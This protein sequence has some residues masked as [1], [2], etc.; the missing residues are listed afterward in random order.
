VFL[1]PSVPDLRETLSANLPPWGIPRCRQHPIF[2][3]GFPALPHSLSS[4]GNKSCRDAFAHLRSGDAPSSQA[5]H[6][7]PLSIYPL[8]LASSST[9]SSPASPSLPRLL[10]LQRQA[11]PLRLPRY[12][13][14]FVSGTFPY[15][16]PPLAPTMVRHGIMCSSLVF[17]NLNS[18]ANHGYSTQGILN[19]GYS[20]TSSATSTSA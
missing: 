10:H 4:C 6:R 16:P 17:G 15:A 20:P 1:A 11:G 8:R 12:I 5:T 13:T 14:V 9:T 19:H 2:R 3:S 18:S 7:T